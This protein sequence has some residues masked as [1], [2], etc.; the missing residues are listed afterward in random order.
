[1]IVNGQWFGRIGHMEHFNFEQG[2]EKVWIDSFYADYLSNGLQRLQMRS[3]GKDYVFLIPLDIAKKI[4]KL[5]LQH[6]ESYEKQTGISLDDRLSNEPMKSNLLD[7]KE[8]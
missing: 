6:V 7:D 4:A 5:S 8:D 3:G 1:M 2:P